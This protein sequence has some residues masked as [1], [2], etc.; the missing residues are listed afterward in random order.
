MMR[1]L[2]D[3]GKESQ[4]F[5]TTHSTNFLDSGAMRNVYLASRSDGKTEIQ[6]LDVAAAE[7][8]LPRELG[9]RLSSLFMYDRLVFVEGASDE[10]VFRELAALKEINLGAVGVGFVPMG[11][12]RNLAHFAADQTLAFLSKRQVRMWFVIDR[13]EK[14]DGEVRKLAKA[15]SSQAEVKVLQRREIEN[16]LVEP[17]ALASFI[18]VKRG[19]AGDTRGAPG[20]DEVA[21]AI[22]QVADGLKETTVAFRVAK[23]SCVPIYPR[24]DIVRN[25]DDGAILEERLLA[26]LDAQQAQLDAMRSEAMALVKDVRKA[27]DDKWDSR[28]REIVPGDL[29]LDGV[30]RRFDVRFIKEND[31]GRLAHLLATENIPADLAALIVDIGSP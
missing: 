8:T 25:C 2:R 22:D 23:V 28:K 31:A 17:N 1:Y 13:D 19:M 20:V 16:Y 27:V 26:A 15:L 3:A 10:D 30:C 7:E 24:R 4:V 18:K 14:E 5:V 6:K 11:G 9:I 29:L 12:V 21:A